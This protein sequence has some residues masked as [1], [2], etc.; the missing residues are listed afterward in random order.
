MD[1]RI[2][3][4]AI[5]LCVF[6][7]LAGCQQAATVVPS[8]PPFTPPVI[9]GRLSPAEWDAA[10]EEAFNGGSQLFMMS[11]GKY[12]YLGIRANF[13]GMLMGNVFI[14]QGDEI[15]ILHISAA[16]GT[17]IYTRGAEKWQLQQGFTWQ[18]RED[19][20]SP[21]AM[22]KREAFLQQE[23]WLGS[24]S[25][26]GTPEELEYQILLSGEP[27]H[28]LVIFESMGMRGVRF[29]WPG[30]VVDTFGELSHGDPPPRCVSHRRSGRR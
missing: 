20:D 21:A 19:S 15:S 10:R 24:I 8:A 5:A 29:L 9:D 30:I 18:C 2:Q 26:R 16:L 1:K 12:L 28:L 13:A 27:L 17:A 3:F 14:Q 22:A 7:L 6:S 25:Y 11:D 23:G 4:S